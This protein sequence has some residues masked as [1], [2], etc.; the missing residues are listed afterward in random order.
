[1]NEIHSELN[2]ALGRMGLKRN[3]PVGK[4]MGSAVWAHAIYAA[5]VVPNGLLAAVPAL[6][7][8]Y[9]IV[10][11][12]LRYDQKTGALCLIECPKF[13]VEDEPVIGRTLLISGG[14]TRSVKLTEPSNNPLIY[15][16]KWMFVMDDYEEFDVAQS[17][18]RSLWWKSQMGSDRA[19]SSRIGRL[20][21]WQ[22]WLTTLEK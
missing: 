1:M 14:D 18:L 16:H 22:S 12:V 6:A 10:P 2:L 20:S 13:D 9:G 3:S 17:K 4:R 7:S 8:E 15:H 19:L 21:F 5:H 11:T